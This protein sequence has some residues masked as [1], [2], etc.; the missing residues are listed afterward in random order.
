MLTVDTANT[1]DIAYRARVYDTAILFLSR[2]VCF[3][4]FGSRLELIWMWDHHSDLFQLYNNLGVSQLE[5]LQVPQ[6]APV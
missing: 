3:L 1:Q 4:T 5:L 6:V 2:L